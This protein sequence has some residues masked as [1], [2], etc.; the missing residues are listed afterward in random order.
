GFFCLIL[1]RGLVGNRRSLP[2]GKARKR[3]ASHKVPSGSRIAV[4]VSA[5]PRS[6][7]QS[8][9]QLFRAAGESRRGRERHEGRLGMLNGK[10]VLVTGGTGSF[11]KAFLKTVLARYPGIGR[12]V[13]Y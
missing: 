9:T 4:L 10:S 7:R 1:F 3:M 13:V 6:A 2:H 5:A 12:L 8:A 11:G